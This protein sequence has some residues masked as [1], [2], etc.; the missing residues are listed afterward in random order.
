MFDADQR[1][2]V[3][4][5]RGM[6]C[7]GCVAAVEQSL[8]A[9]P[10]VLEASVSLP[11]QQAIVQAAARTQPQQLVRAIS[12]V[13]Y[14]AVV[15]P[16]KLMSDELAALE[17]EQRRELFAWRNRFAAAF[18]CT[19]LLMVLG[20]VAADFWLGPSLVFALGTITQVYVGWPYYVGAWRRLSRGRADMDTLVALGTTAAYA[21]SLA[22]LI[23]GRQTHGYFHESGML[24][25]LITLGKW[26]EA[27][28]RRQT[29]YAVRQLM[30]L[31]PPIARVLRSG[32]EV[33]V[34]ADAVVVDDVVVVHPGENI[35]VDGEV[36]DGASQVDESLITG[37]TMP[38]SKVFGSRVVGGTVNRHGLLR[39]KA[40]AVGES[41]VL[42]QIVRTVRQAQASKAEV[43]RL[44]DRV[45][46]VFVPFVLL[47]AAATF[48]GHAL[49][50]PT[51]FAWQWATRHA[52]AVLVVAC[53]CALGLATPTA[54]VVGVGI[55]ARRG[56]LIRNAAALENVGRLDT[57][58]LDKTGTLTLGRPTV[59][60]VI[61]QDRYTESDLLRLAGA[62]ESASN[63]PLGAAIVA[64]SRAL[65]LE[66]PSPRNARVE[67]GCGIVADVDGRTIAVG[68]STWLEQRGVSMHLGRTVAEQLQSRG[69]TVVLVGDRDR[70]AGI[71]GVD[72]PVKPSAA[73]AGEQLA[74]LGLQ[75]YLV[76]GDHP[77]AALTAA[78]QA[79]IRA[80]RVVARVMPEEKSEFVRQL[81]N[82][83]HTVAMVGD[84]INDAPALAAADLGIAI[85]AGADIAKE[86]GDVVLVTTD[87]GAI[88][89]AIRL[90][91]LT[92]RKIR[93]NLFWAFVYNVLL[94]PLAALGYLPPLVAAGAMAASSISV[95]ANSLLLRRAHV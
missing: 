60:D 57:V 12:Q 88:P 21:D 56:I 5:V 46:G 73:P 14:E 1:Q 32:R 43:Q 61:P 29:G 33:E 7:A 72:D 39:L 20:H 68:S 74:Q 3:L 48:V 47:V 26:L 4:R 35:P 2:I 50:G 78:E 36:V 63:H 65:G 42:A 70:L 58:V 59:T 62:A 22:A 28:A 71:I 84:G 89:R 75:V 13:G 44:V 83:G 51:G 6:H 18:I 85:G 31:E 23:V 81:Q 40:T 27:R 91:R 53:P 52:I 87:L 11:A 79:G 80:D 34:P 45:A 38:V 17:R 30:R 37:E 77:G 41:T 95:V 54:I 55:G 25:G 16:T 19:L 82:G 92:L 66:L 86:T 67:A 64:R 24:L 8:R 94:I 49:L 9:V 90:G 15:E 10:G 76:T 93:Q 69:K